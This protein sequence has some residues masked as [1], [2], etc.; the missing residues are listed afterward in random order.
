ML[1]WIMIKSRT[2]TTRWVHSGTQVQATTPTARGTAVKHKWVS[3]EFPHPLAN[4][5]VYLLIISLELI[6]DIITILFNG[7]QNPFS[8]KSCQHNK[9]LIASNGSQNKRQTHGSWN[10]SI[11]FFFFLD[12]KRERKYLFVIKEQPFLYH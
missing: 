8:G 6:T 2:R 12:G 3:L 4:A 10:L 1:R 9:K 11:H 7:W 5:A